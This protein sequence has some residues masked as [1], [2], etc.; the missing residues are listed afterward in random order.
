MY[1][2]TYVHSTHYVHVLIPVVDIDIL[3]VLIPDVDIDIACVLIP[4]IDIDIKSI[5]AG[6]YMEGV[7]PKPKMAELLRA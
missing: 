6:H 7:V 2:R 1:I 5:I 3:C 4:V